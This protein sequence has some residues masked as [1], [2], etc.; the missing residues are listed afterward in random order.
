[1]PGGS[2]GAV[3]LLSGENVFLTGAAGSGKSYLIRKFLA[4]LGSGGGRGAFPVLASTGA[5]AILLGGRTFHSFFG[6][7]I[8]EGRPENVIERALKDR[9]VI[10]RLKECEGFILD[11]ISMI[12]GAAFE[13]ANHH[14]TA[15]AR[16][17]SSVGRICA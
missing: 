15:R 14:C 5:A 11:E 7:G 17:H 10:K 1:M 9:R 12:P 16:Q 8:M 6:L 2:F 4:T 13:V 3:K